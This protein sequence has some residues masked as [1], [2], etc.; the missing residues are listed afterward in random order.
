VE[1]GARGSRYYP[2]DIGCPH[3]TNEFAQGDINSWPSRPMV[4]AFPPPVKAEALPLPLYIN[5]T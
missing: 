1:A 3:F 2:A 5:S 4:S